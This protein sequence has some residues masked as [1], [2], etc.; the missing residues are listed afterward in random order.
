MT[1]LTFPP[2]A[3]RFA[4]FLD[5]EYCVWMPS[6]SLAL[7]SALVTGRGRP[8]RLLV[9]ENAPAF[10]SKIGLVTGAAPVIVEPNTIDEVLR[11]LWRDEGL[12]AELIWGIATHRDG[13]LS[14]TDWLS[15]CAAS[16]VPTIEL[17]LGSL[18]ALGHWGPSPSMFTIVDLDA[19]AAFS[20]ARVAALLTG[21]RVRAARVQKLCLPEPGAQD[22]VF[23]AWPRGLAHDEPALASLVERATS[24]AG[25]QLLTAPAGVPAAQWK[26]PVAVAEDRWRSLQSQLDEQRSLV[27]EWQRRFQTAEGEAASRAGRHSAL[28]SEAQKALE[29]KQ[30]SIDQWEARFREAESETERDLASLT[31][32]RAGLD[33]RKDEVETALA[34]IRA[35]SEALAQKLRRAE[36]E[37]DLAVADAARRDESERLIRSELR[38]RV[39]QFEKEAAAL[40][41]REARQ[42]EAAETS[43][44]G[45]AAQVARLEKDAAAFGEARAALQKQKTEAERALASIQA[46]KQDLTRKLTDLD[47]ELGEALRD[48]AQRAAGQRAALDEQN[49]RA[50]QLEKAVASLTG[51]AAAHVRELEAAKSDVS[52]RIAALETERE[53]LVKRL[54]TVEAAGAGAVTEAARREE[55]QRAEIGEHKARAA[56]LGKEVAV[57]R[58]R[59]AAHPSEKETAQADVSGRIAFLEE[60]RESLVQRL[61]AVEAGRDRSAAEAARRE[62]VQGAEIAGQKARADG[63]E[64]EAVALKEREAL[65]AVEGEKARATLS[66]KIRRLEAASETAQKALVD[67]L[68]EKAGF[69]WALAQARAETRVAVER[70]AEVERT[71]ARGGAEETGR[72]EA[73]SAAQRDLL[74]QK[75]ESE[76]ERHSLQ[77]EKDALSRRLA[78]VEAECDRALAEASGARDAA[79]EQAWKSERARMSE[80]IA[81]LE[82]TA[83]EAESLHRAMTARMTADAERTIASLRAENDTVRGKVKELERTQKSDTDLALERLGAGTGPDPGPAEMALREEAHQAE[84]MAQ[85]ELLEQVRSKS[86]AAAQG[87]ARQAEVW[88]ADRADLMA[89]I[90]RLEA[91]GVMADKARTEL[92]NRKKDSDRALAEA[93]VERGVL[94]KKLASAEHERDQAHARAARNAP[95]SDRPASAAPGD[96]REKGGERNTGGLSALVNLWNTALTKR[97]SPRKE[98]REIPPQSPASELFGLEVLKAE[99]TPPADPVPPEPPVTASASGPEAGLAGGTSREDGKVRSTPAAAQSWGPPA[100]AGNSGGL[101]ALV[102]LWTTAKTLRPFR[103]K[104]AEEKPPGP[105]AEPIFGIEEMPAKGVP[106]RPPVAAEPGDVSRKPDHPIPG[107]PGRPNPPRPPAPKPVPPPPSAPDR[108]EELGGWLRNLG[109]RMRPKK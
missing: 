88:E 44:A 87:A 73:L 99:V 20:G 1:D 10:I 2:S 7:L 94:L 17:C 66:D 4:S 102:N 55:A 71:H 31:S 48:A 67:L 64:T 3:Q 57:L 6:P 104:E 46:E 21:D 103:R 16:G 27:E 93:A 65:V 85:R 12:S 106:S 14:S 90:A 26:G 33:R 54:T 100:A 25:D 69:E 52:G 19:E 32:A 97:P 91:A 47:A 78:E 61:S 80:Q 56:Q 23:D 11:G 13:K 39:E 95:G 50:A 59:E 74:A 75:E 49:Q 22:Y 29:E 107:A 58:E 68:G 98:T 81:N 76:R 8:K 60:E 96:P 92:L 101:S 70:L 42:A 89:R 63:L 30:R 15:R 24:Q 45:L 9:T 83:E 5:R 108:T 43:R 38:Q 18:Q 37:R 62:E 34:S 105:P 40:K 79:R 84:L 28:L 36:R 82:A 51:R 41:G 86:A 109:N 77:S 53:T 72:D 35:E